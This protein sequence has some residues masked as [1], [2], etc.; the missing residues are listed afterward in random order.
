MPWHQLTVDR[1]AHDPTDLIHRTFPS[2]FEATGRPADMA[3]FLRPQAEG[4][5]VVFYFAPGAYGFATSVAAAPCAPPPRKNMT[6]IAG[7][8]SS[9][10]MLQH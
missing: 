2:I 4:E 5:A 6:L 8:P 9:W 10:A 1:T 7:E 3:I